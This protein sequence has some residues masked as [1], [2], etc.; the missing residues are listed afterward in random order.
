MQN[1]RLIALCAVLAAVPQVGFSHP[2]PIRVPH[3]ARAN[4]NPNAIQ[5]TASCAAREAPTAAPI[6]HLRVADLAVDSSKL[7]GYS[8]SSAST[9]FIRQ[10]NNGLYAGFVTLGFAIARA[11]C[12]GS[13]ILSGDV[14]AL[15]QVDL[16]DTANSMVTPS[17]VIAFDVAR[18]RNIRDSLPSMTGDDAFNALL[19]FANSSVVAVANAQLSCQQSGSSAVPPAMESMVAAGAR[20]GIVTAL[21]LC[22]PCNQSITDDVV[23]FINDQLSIASDELQ[24]F[25][26]CIRGFNFNLFNTIPLGAPFTSLQSYVPLT[27]LIN[28][29][30]QTIL[31]N[32]CTCSPS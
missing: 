18:V 23:S 32:D 27:G 16:T 31:A 2:R 12:A 17:A 19:D 11:N 3:F 7:N 22:F 4:S 8:A 15:M 21:A 25:A 14:L 30:A 20:L 28:A 10:V 1:S 29:V 6:P 26:G 24:A 5:N 13:A 9:L